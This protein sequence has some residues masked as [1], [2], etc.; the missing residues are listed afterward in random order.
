MRHHDEIMRERMGNQPIICHLKK[1]RDRRRFIGLARSPGA[2]AAESGHNRIIRG[3]KEGTSTRG[4]PIGKIVSPRP[5]FVAHLVDTGDPTRAVLGN[6]PLP[7]CRTEIEAV[8]QVLRLDEDVC[9]EQ[10]A[11]QSMAPTS[12]P[13]L[14]NVSVF[15]TPSMRKASR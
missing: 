2:H 5:Q 8:V 10:E 9:V 3:K 4:R 13:I 14:L 12:R 6:K 7:E 15:E 11:G 1:R